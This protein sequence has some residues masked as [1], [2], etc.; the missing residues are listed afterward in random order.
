MLTLLVVISKQTPPRTP[1]RAQKQAHRALWHRTTNILIELQSTLEKAMQEMAQ[2]S[3]I[4]QDI[5]MVKTVLAKMSTDFA[6][7][8]DKLEQAEAHIM[9][10]KIENGWLDKEVREKVPG[11]EVNGVLSS[12]GRNKLSSGRLSSGG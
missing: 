3:N 1:N 6:D 11:I 10:F 8:H 12:R 4:L 5:S 9:D 2:V 7:L